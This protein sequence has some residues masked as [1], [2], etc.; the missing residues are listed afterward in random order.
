[1][2]RCCQRLSPFGAALLLGAM[3]VAPAQSAT[4]GF[5][6]SVVGSDLNGPLML[7]VP[8]LGVPTAIE[9]YDEIDNGEG[10]A[11]SVNGF[12]G[13]LNPADLTFRYGEIE[14]FSTSF[15]PTGCTPTPPPSGS[16]CDTVVNSYRDL[17]GAPSF[18][19]IA[20]SGVDILEGEVE[21]IVVTT[22]SNAA[23]P[24]FTTA[25]GTFSGR[26]TTWGTASNSYFTTLM[27]V[28]GGTGAFTGILNTFNSVCVPGDPSCTFN[29]SGSLTFVPEPT[30]ALLLAL[31]LTGLGM[32]RR[33]R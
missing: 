18:I 20:L 12:L 13:S 28:S 23:S 9:A 33:V 22:N 17:S 29:N 27:A 11:S 6:G 19:T 3:L 4:I 1:M 32:R 8:Y 16:N 10:T 24:G 2:T 15:T 26:I 31:G 14:R 7:T 21:T 30:T 5:N 25:T